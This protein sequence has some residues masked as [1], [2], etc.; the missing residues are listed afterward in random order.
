MKILVIGSGGREHAL[1]WKIAQSPRVEKIYCAPGNGGIEETAEC[2]D[3]KADDIGGLLKFALDY[4]I[5]LTV[6]GPE[7]ALGLGIVDLFLAN[8]LRIFGPN[9]KAAMLEG[10][11]AFSKDFMEKHGIPTAKYKNY[12]DKNMAL[13][14]IVDFGYPMVIKADGL[15]AGKG[16]L[17]A[18]N[19]A[20]AE[21]AINEIMGDKKFGAAG[22][23][24]VIEEFLQGKEASIL[25]FVDGNIAIPMVSAQDYKRALD[26]DEGLNTGG[27]GAVSPA[28]YYNDEIAE[29]VKRDI[30]DKT[31]KAF[32][33]EGIEYKGV[34]YFGLM[35]TKEG[36]KL[37]EYNARFGD[38]ETEVVL[39]RLETD[40]I[41]IIDAVIDGGLEDIS[42]NWS[43]DSAVCVV[44]ASGGYPESYD[45]GFQIKGLTYNSADSVIFHAGTAIADGKAITTGG[46]V[47]V[48]SA[49]GKTSNQ[50][51]ERAYEMASKIDFKKAFYRKDIGVKK[52]SK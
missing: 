34:L 43:N 38:P 22:N 50:A 41:D 6:V 29:V 30:I 2:I 17:I 32:K 5:D 26:D 42:I 47:L 39:M 33:A 35:L 20:E 44:I 52:G 51:R 4:E 46:R 9:K 37:L 40:L 48:V 45:T 16:V 31:V 11:K 23:T 8:N 36:P 1:V 18:E 10:S 7:V 21:A 13:A 27:M 49:L 28:F 3:I 19:R 14:E 15:A 25:A 12:T 24:I